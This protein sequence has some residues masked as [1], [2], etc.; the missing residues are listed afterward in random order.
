MTNNHLG[1]DLRMKALENARPLHA[2]GKSV[3]LS[4]ET[5]C[6]VMLLLIVLTVVVQFLG[7]AFV[8]TRQSDAKM[9]AVITA[10]QIAEDFQASDTVEEF[11]EAVG[12]TYTPGN[13]NMLMTVERIKGTPMNVAVQIT[14]QARQLGTLEQATIKVASPNNPSVVFEMQT[15]HYVQGG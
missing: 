6:A 4:I 10:R 13:Q 9:S 11:C 12:V 8:L 2:S 7:N 1:N 15:S 5:I 14:E 3:A